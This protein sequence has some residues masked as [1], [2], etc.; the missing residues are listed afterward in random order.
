MSQSPGEG[1]PLAEGTLVS[2]LLELRDRL[3]RAFIAVIIVFVPCAIY[4]NELFTFL[5]Q[6]LPS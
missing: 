6:P 5:A 2:H 4:S 3:L 1:E